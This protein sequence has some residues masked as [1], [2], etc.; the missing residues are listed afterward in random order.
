MLRLAMT[1]SL[2]DALLPVEVREPPAELAALDRFWPCGGTVPAWCS[3][4]LA[5]AP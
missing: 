2:F 3:G 4:N 1:R 5:Y